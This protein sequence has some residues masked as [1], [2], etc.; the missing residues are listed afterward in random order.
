MS[1]NDTRRE[2]LKKSAAATSVLGGGLAASSG[3]AA[4]ASAD[5][6]IQATGKG[7]FQIII[8]TDTLD[9]Q[10]YGDSLDAQQD[11]D[12]W[13][14]EGTVDGQPNSTPN[15]Y[16][17]AEFGGYGDYYNKTSDDGVELDVTVY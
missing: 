14:I 10:K 3:S 17:F 1:Q 16:F 8:E 7:S 6:N 4:A 5:G 15:E 2:F 11:G 12:F 9:V 13:D